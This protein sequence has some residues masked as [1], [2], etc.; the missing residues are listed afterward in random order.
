MQTTDPV[1]FAQKANVKLEE[2]QKEM[3]RSMFDA[4]Q[5]KGI[6]FVAQGPTG[7]GKTYCIAAVTAALVDQGKRVCIAV[8]TYAHLET[9]M[10]PHLNQL[11]IKY[12]KWR[13]VTQLK[14]GEGCPYK[15]W[16]LPSPMFCGGGTYGPDTEKCE[17]MDCAMRRDYKD[18]RASK[19]VLTVFHKLLANPK[20]LDMFDVVVFDES[21]SLEPA[22]RSQRTCI[23]KGDSIDVL[24]SFLP[25]LKEEFELAK[26]SLEKL[27]KSPPALIELPLPYVQQIAGSM[28]E[29]LQKVQRAI[30]GVELEKKQEIEPN[31]AEAYY[32]LIR[33]TQALNDVESYRYERSGGANIIAIPQQVTFAPPYSPKLG[34]D[35]SIVLVSAT[36]ENPKLHARDAGFPYH[37]LTPPV[38]IDTDRAPRLR[39]RF[40]RRPM[41]GLID[42]PILR[43][44]PTNNE[45][46]G[47]ARKEANQIAL[48]VVMA[49]NSPTL[50]LCRSKEDQ[51]SI[52]QT[53]TSS[54]QLGT[55]LY[56]LSE[57]DEALDVDRLTDK[58]NAEIRRG[59]NIILASASSRLWEGANIE[60]LRLLVVD[61]LPYPAPEPR[62]RRNP[63]PWKTSHTFRFMLRR[64]QQGIGRL[65]RKEN[66]YGIVVVIDGRFYAHWRTLKS[67]LPKYMQ[68]PLEF[69]EQS[70]LV[71]KVSAT[72][73]N[74]TSSRSVVA[75]S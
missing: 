49:V 75:T 5:K 66:D 51:K 23:L 54:D 65:V 61:S 45:A 37:K 25:E 13:G 4:V 57:A 71:Q 2:D 1:E 53:I 33:A 11:G 69:V 22:L 38:Q 31:L 74:L 55:R 42:G 26:E 7:M 24:T 46:F 8:P 48:K 70:R 62:E 34:L 20:E 28:K 47:N 6:V 32:D 60:D 10:G 9:V 29:P 35:K 19:V 15:N 3:A 73:E 43:K 40:Q 14:K 39:A 27:G 18:V 56:S 52:E 63:G 67:E 16:S 59:R 17:N 12:A 50:I 72:M 64:L 44:D 36:I 30:E 21:H 68:E 41:F 58:I